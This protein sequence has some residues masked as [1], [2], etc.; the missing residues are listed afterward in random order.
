PL[1]HAQ[2]R[3]WFLHQLE[4]PSPTYNVPM[5]L[6]LTGELDT[7][8]LREAICDLAD[9]H[10]S[11]RTV[12]PET[13]GTPRQQV[14]HGDAARPTIEVVTTDAAHLAEHIATAAR[15]AFRLTD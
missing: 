7:T 1:S 13:D 9:R 3:L 10:E 6:R 12:F 5:A 8:A 2:R 14:L 11:L 4:G 15:H